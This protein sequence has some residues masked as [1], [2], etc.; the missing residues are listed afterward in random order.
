[1]SDLD[2]KVDLQLLDSNLLRSSATIVF[3]VVELVIVDGDVV[4]GV[5]VGEGIVV[6]SEVETIDV[7]TGSA[8]TK[9]VTCILLLTC[10]FSSNDLERC[11][12]FSQSI[13]SYRTKSK[14]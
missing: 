2:S 12:R 7:A 5:V 3:P 10:Q 9:S 8:E 14:K 4:D 11:D 6:A 13:L 1:M